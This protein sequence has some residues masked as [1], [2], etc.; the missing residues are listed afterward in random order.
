MRAKRKKRRLIAQYILGN[1]CQNCGEKHPATF[2][3]HHIDPENKEFDINTGIKRHY[4]LNRFI[5]ELVKCV[6]LCS[7]CHRIL[8]HEEVKNRRESEE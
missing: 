8:H 3:Y 2:D 6:L 5:D 4:A 1:E 7:N